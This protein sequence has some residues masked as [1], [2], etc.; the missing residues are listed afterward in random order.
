[1][2]GLNNLKDKGMNV[3]NRS[4]FLDRDGVI[5][6]HKEGGYILHPDEFVFC[7]GVPEAM[8]IMARYFRYIF[9]VTNQRGI[10]K[11]LMTVE[12]LKEIHKKMESGINKA[13]GRIDGIYFCPDTDEGSPNRKPNPGM[14]FQAKR[15]YPGVDFSTSVMVGNTPGDMRFGK[16]L[17]MH[18]VFITSTIFPAPDLPGLIDE[19]FPCLHDYARSFE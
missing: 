12:D 14:G 19:T 11:G 2:T 13:G 17:G 16:G 6:I 8:A 18:N 5:N 3:K 9:I 10:G 7:E 4:L 1:M 15:D